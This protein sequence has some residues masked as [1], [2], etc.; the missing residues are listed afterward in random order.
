MI[1]MKESAGDREQDTM[2]NPTTINGILSQPLPE[3]KLKLLPLLWNEVPG[4]SLIQRQA[5]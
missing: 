3:P 5:F 4:L 1:C 2:L